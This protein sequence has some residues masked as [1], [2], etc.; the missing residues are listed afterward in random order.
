MQALNGIITVNYGM[1]SRLRFQKQHIF[2][3]IWGSL[4]HGNPTCYG[5][6]GFH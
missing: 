4:Y 2:I 5:G 3:I 6:V 1:L